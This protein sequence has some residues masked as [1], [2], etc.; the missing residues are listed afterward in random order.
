MLYRFESINIYVCKN[1]DK[2]TEGASESIRM[3][4]QLFLVHIFIQL[5]LRAKKYNEVKT[6]THSHNF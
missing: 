2:H 6:E 4:I 5:I 3:I 1:Y